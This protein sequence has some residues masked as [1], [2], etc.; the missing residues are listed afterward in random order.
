MT[1][2]TEFRPLTGERALFD[3]PVCGA[4]Y[5]GNELA[6]TFDTDVVELEPEVTGLWHERIFAPSDRWFRTSACGCLYS[7]RSFDIQVISRAGPPRLSRL[8]V[9][10][11]NASPR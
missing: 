1:I 8:L 2:E 5:D 7:M 4:H 11:Q 6:T 3:C 9:V 10:P